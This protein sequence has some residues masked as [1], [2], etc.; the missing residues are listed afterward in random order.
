MKYMET[1]PEGYLQYLKSNPDY[2]K[3]CNPKNKKILVIQMTDNESSIYQQ[4]L[5]EEWIDVC[6]SRPCY[7]SDR[8]TR[9]LP[10]SVRDKLS[11]SGSGSGQ[12]YLTQIC[13]GMR[14]SDKPSS[15][16]TAII[17][18]DKLFAQVVYNGSTISL[19]DLDGNYH[20][21]KPSKIIKDI[22]Q[23]MITEK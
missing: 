19:I 15:E 16:E 22:H 10:K 3:Y 11:G 12:S 17:L 5:E 21:V 23:Y 8:T 18:G 13:A 14:S 9:C 6:T 4:W 20:L 2:Q 7:R 1:C